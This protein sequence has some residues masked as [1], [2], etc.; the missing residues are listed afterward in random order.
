MDTSISHENLDFAY[1]L[2]ES[3][4]EEEQQLGKKMQEVVAELVGQLKPILRYITAPIG[5]TD[6]PPDTCN[7]EMAGIGHAIS[8]RAT[9]FICFGG[10]TLYL[11]D[12]GEFFLTADCTNGVHEHVFRVY[13]T[14]AF[15]WEVFPFEDFLSAL[16]GR[17]QKALEQREQH[18]S[19]I[20]KRAEKLDE[21][22]ALLRKE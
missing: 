12:D 2:L 18:L 20:R 11:R 21:V 19:S 15:T 13:G 9:A 1:R 10:K 16:Q 7:G 17:L 3:G 6:S 14:C 4:F 8:E 5:L 22:I